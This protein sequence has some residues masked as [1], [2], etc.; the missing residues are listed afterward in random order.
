MVSKHVART[1]WGGGVCGE[2]GGKQLAGAGLAGQRRVSADAQ[3]EASGGRGDSL[4]VG[5]VGAQP[6]ARLARGHE[7]TAHSGARE[8]R[9]TAGVRRPRGRRGG[10]RGAGG[11]AGG[12]AGGAGP[13]QLRGGLRA[14]SSMRLASKPK[15]HGSKPWV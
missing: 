1:G 5:A 15:R 6:L 4:L 12:S 3:G 10:R 2:R 13:G 9:V 14:H 7:V 8:A 11:E